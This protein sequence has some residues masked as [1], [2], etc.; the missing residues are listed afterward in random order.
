MATKKDL[1][2]YIKT[3]FDKGYNETQLREALKKAGH[4]KTI[5]DSAFKQ[6]SKEKEAA[7]LEASVPKAPGA[8][9]AAPTAPSATSTTAGTGETELSADTEKILAA[10]AYPIGIIVPIILLAMAKEKNKFGKFHG[11]QALFWGITYFVI[12]ILIE[13]IFFPLVLMRSFWFALSMSWLVWLI[14]TLLWLTYLGLSIMFAIKAYQGQVFKI[15]IIGNFVPAK[16][17]ADAGVV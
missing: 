12:Y 16:V 4:S 8:P 7:Q 3:N 2:E 17:R 13:V 9:K 5:V 6:A 1:V 14:G 10:L 15:P 11:F